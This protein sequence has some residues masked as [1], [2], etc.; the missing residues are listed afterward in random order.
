M[1]RHDVAVDVVGVGS[2]AAGTTYLSSIIK[3]I[4]FFPHPLQHLSPSSFS[5]L[6]AAAAR[7]H[8][9]ITN[10][11]LGAASTAVASAA[12]AGAAAVGAFVMLAV[13]GRGKPASRRVA[14]LLY[15][16]SEVLE[17][18]IFPAF[19]RHSFNRRNNDKSFGEECRVGIVTVRVYARGGGGLY[20][21]KCAPSLVSVRLRLRVQQCVCL[22]VCLY[23]RRLSVG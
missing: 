11:Q 19:I 6:V 15:S 18:Q 3:A 17:K 2:C 7:R 23:V 5:L 10:Q 22:F 8:F 13:K 20:V 12:G 21:I 14:A 9:P 16:V 4:F 1:D